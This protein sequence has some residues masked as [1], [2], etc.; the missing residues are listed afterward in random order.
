MLVMV[1]V[2]VLVVIVVVV[3]LVV[4]I[5]TV[6]HFS[7]MLYADHAD[8]QAKAISEALYFVLVVARIEPF[9]MATLTHTGE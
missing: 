3:V 1:V 4:V 2:V 5:L 8:N 7:L 6:V 9:R